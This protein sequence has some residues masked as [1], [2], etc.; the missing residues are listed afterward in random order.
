MFGEHT[1]SILL[2][3]GIAL[4]AFFLMRGASRRRAAPSSNS[5]PPSDRGRDIALADAP[6]DLLR[7][8][9][10]LHETARDL[11]AELDSK[12]SAMQTLVAMAR[13]ERALLTTS[14][15]QARAAGIEPTGGT[16]AAIE[17]LGDPAALEDP[18][19]LALVAAQM[20]PLPGG[21][22]GDLFEGDRTSLAISRLADQG[23]A[24]NSIAEQLNLP[25]GEVELKLSLR[26]G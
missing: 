26:T 25:L 12:L 2:V 3:A 7:W 10:E 15:E 5:T 4:A 23:L 19:R 16:L 13:Q 6:P 22:P 11:K 17:G 20:P 14:I 1:S 21:V 24:P 8:Q 9:V 18:G